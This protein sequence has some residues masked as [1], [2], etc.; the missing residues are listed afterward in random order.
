VLITNY[1]SVSLVFHS[2]L[3]EYKTRGKKCHGE[4][5]RHENSTSRINAVRFEA[6]QDLEWLS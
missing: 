4:E 6:W 2:F 5:K 3:I 1:D